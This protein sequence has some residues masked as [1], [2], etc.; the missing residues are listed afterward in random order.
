MNI[1]EII[2]LFGAVVV[3]TWLAGFALIINSLKR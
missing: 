2:V 1:N 3:F